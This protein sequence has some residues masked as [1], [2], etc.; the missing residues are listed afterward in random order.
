LS[1]QG[2][3]DLNELGTNALPPLLSMLASSDSVWKEKFIS[4]LSEKD[5]VPERFEL[6]IRLQ[7]AEV[8]RMLAMIALSTL[9]RSKETLI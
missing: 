1:Q 2:E 7:S 8:K 6:R 9:L 4:Y 3:K 5:L